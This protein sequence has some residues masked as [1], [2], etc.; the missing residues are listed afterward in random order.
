MRTGVTAAF[1][2]C[3]FWGG[4]LLAAARP[5]VATAATAHT[6]LRL[7]SN[8]VTLEPGRP[9]DLGLLFDL[10][11]HWHIYWSN[12]GDSGE[13]PVVRWRLPEG[14]QAA[15][16]EWP[17]PQRLVNGPLTDY[18]YQG[19][20]LLLAPVR[21]PPGI[22]QPEVTLSA[23]VRWLVCSNVCVPAEASVSVALPVKRALPQ[24]DA[25]TIGLFRTARRGLPRP[26]PPGWRVSAEDEG[27]AFRI[28]LWSGTKIRQA[29]FFPLE[30][31]QVENAKPQNSVPL[32]GGVEVT[33]EK[34]D[35]LL[36]PVRQ[37]RGVLVIDGGRA[38]QI[39]AA[40]NARSNHESL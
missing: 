7:V 16:L 15:A 35:Q 30:F 6:R 40:V 29:S 8:A 2:L 34:S 21:V 39:T 4:G 9:L 3:F 25:Q 27:G 31:N 17:A 23:D 32:A 1:T 19:R 20:V 5:A 37:L 24:P 38:Y 10:D 14:F 13:P 33:V 18:G 28:R 11:P 36:K 26:L 22:K 12:P